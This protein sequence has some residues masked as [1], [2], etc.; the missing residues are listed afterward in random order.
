MALR[1]IALC[2]VLSTLL[3]G[4]VPARADEAPAAPSEGCTLEAHKV[5]GESCV[6]CN[7]WSG[8]AAKCLKRLRSKGYAQRCRGIGTDTWSEVWCKKDAAK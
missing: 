8:D 6:L 2:L 5:A 1:L 7:S 3:Y 4:T